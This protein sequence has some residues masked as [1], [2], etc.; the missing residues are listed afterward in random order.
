MSKNGGLYLDNAVVIELYARINE[1]QKTVEDALYKQYKNAYKITK[2]NYFKGDAADAVKSYMTDG[3]VNIL[4]GMMDVSA[5]MTTIVQL[6][7]ELFIQYEST[8]TGRV[9]ENA[10]DYIKEELKLKESIYDSSKTELNSAI[11]VASKYISITPLN[12]E[13]V[14]TEYT[15][16]NNKLKDIRTNL[17]SFDSAALESANELYER[18]LAAKTYIS[19]MMDYCYNED[20]NLIPDNINK[21]RKQDWYNKSTNVQLYLKLQEDPFEYSAGE[22]TVAEDQ[23]AIGLC[24]DVYAYAGYSFLS[25]SYEAGLEDGTA[26][27]KAKALV[28]EANGYAQFTDYLHAEGEARFGSAEG[29]AKVGFSDDYVGFK[30]DLKVGLVDVNGSVLIGSDDLNAYVKGSAKVLCADGKAAFELPNEDGEFSMGFHAEGT[31]AKAS[32]KAGFS[33]FKYKDHS[34]DDNS[35]SLFKLKVEGGATAG[36]ELSAFLESKKAIETEHCNINAT[37]IDVAIGLGLDIDIELTI[38]TLYFNF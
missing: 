18:I 3:A 36:A 10:L 34:N 26:F 7:S 13:C 11:N 4:A 1:Y 5:E 31:V 20:G 22:V 17:E 32:A 33:M 14:N 37:S 12:M 28:A 30:V 24:S 19:N 25:A 9:E 8:H 16:I 6:M 15:N 38:P 21:V 23:W 29:E 2:S 27:I 35:D